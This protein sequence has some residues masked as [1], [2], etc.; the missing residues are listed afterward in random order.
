ML[1]KKIVPQIK[2]SQNAQVSLYPFHAVDNKENKNGQPGEKRKREAKCQRLCQRR[3][4]MPIM[5][6]NADAMLC[7]A[8]TAIQ[9][10]KYL[11]KTVS[12]AA[13]H[14]CQGLAPNCVYF[15]FAPSITS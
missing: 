14:V 10:C 8:K 9:C 7:N 4:T 11:S 6:P 13:V 2:S 15:F 12:R 1:E 5:S 3:N